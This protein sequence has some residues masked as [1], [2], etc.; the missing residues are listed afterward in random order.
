MKVIAARTDGI[1]DLLSATALFHELKRAGHEVTALVSPYAAPVLDNNPDVSEV[2]EYTKNNT[3]ALLQR[4]RQLGFDASVCIYP[5]PAVASIFRKAGIKKRFGTAYR[6]HSLFN[7]NRP[8]FV[9]RKKS[10]KHESEYNL[11]MAGE[12]ISS[13]LPVRPYMFLS[14][15]ETVMAGNLRKKYALDNGFIIVHPGSKGSAWNPLPESYASYCDAITSDGRRQVFLS[16]AASDIPVVEAVFGKCRNTHRIIKTR[17]DMN[18]RELAALISVS[19]CLVSGSTGPMHIA[20]ALNVPT[21]T[22]FPP[23]SIPQMSVTRWGPKGNK[24]AVI[25]PPDKGDMNM[26]KSGEVLNRIKEVL[27]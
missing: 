21:V 15:E 18:I 26:I 9:H 3:Q 11:D 20:C 24:N 22:F 13:P 2:I 4:V 23:D 14:E 8:V 5:D 1:G 12:L 27:N 16:G 25:K 19:S 7:F 17:F 10:V 6:W